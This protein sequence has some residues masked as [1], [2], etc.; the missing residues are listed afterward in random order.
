SGR[1]LINLKPLGARGLH[2]SEV[3]RRLQPELEKQVPGIKLYMQPVQDL[4]VENRV[5]RTQYQYTL[6]AADA[7]L[8]SEWIP[9]LVERLSALAALTDVATDLQDQGLQA[10]VDIDRDTAGRL[11]IT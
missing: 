11:G 1:I 9:R 4:T 5:S 6:E 10:Y 7:R 3:I 8:L 2:A